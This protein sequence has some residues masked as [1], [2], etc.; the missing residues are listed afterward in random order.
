MLSG[1]TLTKTSVYRSQGFFVS[2]PHNVLICLSKSAKPAPF[3][4]VI[5]ERQSCQ[6]VPV[7]ISYPASH[8][9]AR[10]SLTTLS[11]SLIYLRT[12]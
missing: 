2:F 8:S 6:N 5:V 7:G 12:F 1:K 3:V 9:V 10:Y 11:T 4:G